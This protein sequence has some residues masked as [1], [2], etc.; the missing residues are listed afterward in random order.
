LFNLEIYLL[1]IEVGYKDKQKV[2]GVL[3]VETCFLKQC[4]DN[5]FFSKMLDLTLL[6]E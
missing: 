3:F 2:S 4:S 6:H 5:Y 1:T